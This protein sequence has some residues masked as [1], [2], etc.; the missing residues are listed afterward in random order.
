MTAFASASPLDLTRTAGAFSRPPFRPEPDEQRE[1]IRFPEAIE[2]SPESRMNALKFDA[3]VGFNARSTPKAVTDL[4]N[5]PR[6]SL[7]HI[8]SLSD[9]QIRS[10]LAQFDDADRRPGW[11]KFLDLIDA[12]RNFIAQNATRWVLPEARRM[13]IERGDFDQFGQPKVY[14]ADMLRALGIENR[15]I[16]AVGGFALDIFTDPLS[17]IG[18]PIGGLKTVGSRGAVSIGNQGQKLLR[19]GIDTVGKTGSFASIA[20][21]ATRK[22][23]E[24]TINAGRL[25]GHLD[26]AADGAQLAAYASDT[27]LGQQSLVSRVAERAKIGA[28]TRGGALA[29]DLYKSTNAGLERA[30]GELER[31]QAV[32]NFVARYTNNGKPAGLSGQSGKTAELF[33]VPLTNITFRTRAFDVPGLGLRAG[34]RAELQRAIAL[35]GEGKV[36]GGARLAQVASESKYASQLADRSRE[37][38]ERQRS[39]LEDPED[40]AAE[41]ESLRGEIDAWVSRRNDR[42]GSS[43]KSLDELATPETI[44]DLLATAEFEAAARADLR[45][46]AASLR[47]ADIDKNIP[48]EFTRE[49]IEIARA[50]REPIA[51]AIAN[52]LEIPKDE[53]FDALA[54]PERRTAAM[55]EIIEEYTG[56]VTDRYAGLAK[57]GDADLDAG[58]AYVDALH[59]VL[60]GA[61]EA[62]VYRGTQIRNA[63]NPED[64][65]LMAAAKQIIGVSDDQL[66][67]LPMTSLARMAEHIGASDWASSIA[68]QGMKIGSNLGGVS[69]YQQSVMQAI[70]R[71]AAGADD[72]ASRVAGEFRRGGGVFSGSGGLD[73]IAKRHGIEDHQYDLLAQWA[74]LKAENLAR[75]AAGLPDIPIKVLNDD[76]S[77]TTA[78]RLFERLQAEGLRSNAKLAADIDT[79]ASEAV[80]EFRRLGQD[81]LN[82]G[83]VDSLISAY[84]P[85]QLRASAA[86]R[87]RALQLGKGGDTIAQKTAS[88]LNDPTKGRVTDLVEFK[89]LEGNS[90]RFMLLEADVFGG[91]DEV[92]L[93]Q[94]A[95]EHPDRA[96]RVAQIL[97]DVEAFK[98]VYGDSDQAMKDIAR[99]M[100]PFEL[101]D[102]AAGGAMDGLVG[103]PL[104]RGE[105]MFETNMGNLLYNRTRSARVQEAADMFRDVIEPHI[106]FRIP[107]EQHRALTAETAT[108]ADGTQVERLADGRYR[109]AGVTYRHVQDLDIDTDTIFSPMGV[110]GAKNRDALIPEPLA[111]AVERM[112][113]VLKPENMGAIMNIADKTTSYFKTAT[114]AHP[115][116]TVGN[117]IGNVVLTAMSD[118]ALLTNPKRLAKYM[119]MNREA[120]RIATKMGLGKAIDPNTTIMLAGRPVRMG[121]ILDLAREGGV[122]NGGGMAGDV[123]RQLLRKQGIAPSMASRTGGKFGKY[124]DAAGD[125]LDSLTHLR[126][127]PREE[128]TKL[129]RARAGAAAVEDT[130]FQKAIRYWF[131]LN[132]AVD[133]GFRL[134]YFMNLMD[135]GYDATMAADQTRR[136]LLNFGDMTSFERN[137]IRPLVPFYA[138]TRASLPNMM[139]RTFRDPKQ[140]SSVPKLHT[141][142]EEMFAGEDRLPRWKRPAWLQQTL[143]AQLTNDPESRLAVQLGTLLPQ[144]GVKEIVGA[145]L[146]GLDLLTGQGAGF[147]GQDLMDA[148]NW[149]FGQLGP[150]AKIP[151]ELGFGRESFTGRSISAIQG[152][153]D[154][155]L[156]EY[157]LRQVRPIREAGALRKAFEEGGAGQAAVRFAIG[158]RARPELSE[159]KR[160]QALYFE[161]K[162]RESK[163]RRAIN[164]LEREGDDST[165][166]RIELVRTY[167]EYLRKGVEPEAVPKY[168][169]N[170]LADMGLFSE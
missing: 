13:A 18:G 24:S 7:A 127:A 115:S 36:A 25:A 117:V 162:D 145:G 20:D 19:R 164:K 37:F 83:D 120:W 96:Q 136:A 72:E 34:G 141:A 2:P 26:E 135:D 140:I 67:T 94:L 150:A 66:G 109:K 121:D 43:P 32:K 14:G 99:P 5:A 160:V 148:I 10:R 138:W 92:Q 170:E 112:S 130:V 15:A 88:T 151:S 8:N 137:K 149:S 55:D 65:L 77:P 49:G 38:I 79:I 41:F 75:T 119:R 31:I 129:E 91:I 142:I 87:A 90:R 104:V 134:A 85:S 133:D 45:Q 52:R 51:T 73:G 122:L 53:A 22:L 16:N 100:M 35:A 98:A 68:N 165:G 161:L 152:E 61:A 103:G 59:A 154:V 102:Y 89:D 69:G 108:L 106:A 23:L 168:V 33:H 132:G 21:D 80:T 57:L 128:A 166:K 86:T 167:A 28:G 131:S 27:L 58:E 158:G 169:R 30:P 78:G 146:G 48:Q 143:A 60:D 1:P 11:V 114:L 6:Y 76:G 163:L 39:G 17:W 40:L 126:G 125:R 123:T 9:E 47:L 3:A 111:V 54:N 97:E 42:V 156:D 50:R 62:S 118:P 157:L 46:A 101:N 81:M 113:D 159:S 139:M 93:A 147:T 71:V 153:G 107:Y 105:L 144:E 29:E 63:I 12:P 82:R 64:R 4:R 74:T 110:L 124:T 70:R 116:W 44:D 95:S 84:L 155:D 56:R